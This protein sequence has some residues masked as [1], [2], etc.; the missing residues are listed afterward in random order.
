M[1]SQKNET[2][3]DNGFKWTYL[4]V[5]ED[6]LDPS[7]EI[8][9]QIISLMNTIGPILQR[10]NSTLYFNIYDSTNTQIGRAS[11]P[12]GWAV[13]EALMKFAVNASNI[14]AAIDSTKLTFSADGITLKNGGIEVI[15]ETVSENDGLL[16]TN[17]EKLLYFDELDGNLYISGNITATDGLFKGRLETEE[18][19]FGGELKAASGTFTGELNAATGSFSGHI[20]A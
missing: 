1:P 13:S 11:L 5:K 18:G 3:S 7:A 10:E 4:K 6:F 14:T 16:V 17:K 8:I 12:T 20:D 19:Y 2:I 9:Q 15:K